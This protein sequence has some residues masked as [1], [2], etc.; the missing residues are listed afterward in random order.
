MEGSR[1]LGCGCREE[2]RCPARPRLPRAWQ[3]APGRL[4]CSSLSVA[5]WLELQARQGSP[6]SLAVQVREG[7]IDPFCSV[8]VP[9]IFTPA[10]PGVARAKF[11][12]QFTNQQCPTVSTQGCFPCAAGTLPG[13]PRPS[14]CPATSLCPVGS[15]AGVHTLA[16]SCPCCSEWPE[17]LCC[18]P[19]AAPDI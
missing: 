7:R 8:K 4:R 10:T 15:R 18:P 2:S 1:G 19:Q 3:S 6:A 14:F 13:M 11:K 16:L 5:K 9:V 12:V 17:K